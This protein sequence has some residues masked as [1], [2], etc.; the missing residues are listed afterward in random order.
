[1]SVLAAAYMPESW[2]VP[3]ERLATWFEKRPKTTPQG[4][5]QIT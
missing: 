4:A 2:Y 5:A 3:M 1:M